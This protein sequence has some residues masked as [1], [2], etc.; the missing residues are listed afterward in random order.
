MPT[1]ITEK[2]ND[3]PYSV[4]VV[5]DPNSLISTLLHSNKDIQVVGSRGATVQDKLKEVM[6]ILP[7]LVIILVAQ[8]DEGRMGL[9]LCK[10]IGLSPS[11]EDIPVIFIVK[12]GKG[13]S[14]IE[15]CAFSLGCLDF[16]SRDRE[17]GSILGKVNYYTNMRRVELGLR[18]MLERLN[19]I[20]DI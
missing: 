9:S 3:P 14:G 7:H 6:S 4:F 1:S 2:T 5:N 13:G 15:E 11:T 17:E 10:E 12:D 19:D 18:E 20:E 8:E 16:I